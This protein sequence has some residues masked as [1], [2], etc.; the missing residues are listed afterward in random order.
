MKPVLLLLALAPLS[1]CQTAVPPDVAAPPPAPEA[2]PAALPFTLET[3]SDLLDFHYSWPVEAAAIHALAERLKGEMET[4]RGELLGSAAK[5]QQYRAKSGFPFH[6][7]E[8]LADWTTAGQSRRLLSLSRALY[9]YT[10]GAHGNHGTHGLLWDRASNAEI[11]FTGL[12]ASSGA[13]A[14]LLHD[15]WCKALD[16]ARARKRG[17][18]PIEGDEF[19]RCPALTEIAIVPTDA[20][21][22]GRFDQVTLVADPYVAGPYAEGDYKVPLAV[23]PAVIAALKPEYRASFEVQRQ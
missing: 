15:D 16:A 18:N 1:A 10:G 6:A 2:P 23:T 21:G 3:K 8:G 11:P 9:E 14:R 19:N 5:D 13:P 20:D 22:N 17:A 12:F 4:W 7:Y